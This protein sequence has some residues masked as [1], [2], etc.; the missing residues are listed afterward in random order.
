MNIRA[1]VILRTSLKS[2]KHLHG[3][4]IHKGQKSTTRLP[5]IINQ[6][7]PVNALKNPKTKAIKPNMNVK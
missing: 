3:L 6:I 4:F 2:C 1:E 7:L 5:T